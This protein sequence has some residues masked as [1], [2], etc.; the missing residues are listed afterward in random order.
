LPLPLERGAAAR[1]A[2]P[3]PG[4]GGRPHPRERPGAAGQAVSASTPT[5]AEELGAGLAEDGAPETGRGTLA[6]LVLLLVFTGGVVAARRLP[7]QWV[8]A[9]RAAAETPQEQL[10]RRIQGAL[11][12]K[13]AGKY[14][15]AWSLLR[16]LHDADV[17][18]PRVNLEL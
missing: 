8:E 5:W 12:A 17:G 13:A 10:S 9:E 1:G 2:P 16:K 11:D 15:E 4:A 14:Q 6:L 7:E 3:R 18:E